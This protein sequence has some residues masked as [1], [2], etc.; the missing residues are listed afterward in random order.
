MRITAQYIL[1]FH[2]VFTFTFLFGQGNDM[3]KPVEIH[4]PN[5]GIPQQKEQSD[6]QLAA[7]FFNN[8]E[9]EK[10]LVLY[11]KLYKENNSN[12]YYT[13]YLYCLLRLEEYK[14]AEKLV[15]NQIRDYPEKPKYLVDLGYVYNES[16]EYN[17]ARK[18]FEQALKQIPDNRGGVTELANA[19]HYRNFS[20]YAVEVYQKAGR[21]GPYP[22]LLELGNLY[23]L[24][25]NTAGMITTYLDYID[26][27]PNNIASVQPRL[28]NVLKD[29]PEDKISDFL[30]Y[31][32]LTRVQK[33]PN[34]TYFS[35]MLLWLLIQQKDFEMALTQAK[36]LDRRQNLEG[37]GLYDLANICLSNKAYDQAV[38]AYNAILK[39]GKNNFLYI[40]ARIGLLYAHYMKVTST[41]NPKKEDLENLETE[42]FSVLEEY[43]KNA[44]TIQIMKHLG[45]LSAFYLDDIPQAIELLNEAIAI[46]NAPLKDIAACKI[47]LADILIL[48]GDVWDAKLLYAQVEKLFKQ[49]PIGYEAKFKNAKLSFYIGEYD[50]AKAQLDVLK[51][52]TSKLIA[53]DA[54]RL[55]V[56]IS[57][58]IDSDSSTVALAMYA[59]ADLLF[60]RH[61]NDEAIA[62]LDSIF[63]LA[64]SHPIFDEVI[65]KKAEIYVSEHHFEE[66]IVYLQ[67]VVDEYPDDITADNALFTLAG[68]Y[69][70]E[71]KE[72]DKAMECYQQLLNDYPAS[73]FTV[74]ARKKFR[75]LRGDFEKETLTDEEKFLFNL[76]NN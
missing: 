44:S 61:H 20:D 25:G 58:N 38:E 74:E 76:E 24:T 62:T 34:K 17:K 43:G 35:E 63:L 5:P 8:H 52:A 39:K 21:T 13:Y 37:E 65:L 10:A 11:E 26:Y 27:D 33:N 75:L 67:Q 55:A 6:S 22:Y 9:Y 53:N 2:L 66:A 72:D 7:K 40:D 41:G 14:Q 1:L 30:R 3:L 51:A 73:I 18:Q 60:Y 47:E 71:F 4:P 23:M 12:V 54:L 49:D 69:E 59:K 32:L 68:I 15:K 19:F 16:G 29:D 48:N 56:L 50:W 64:K 46:Y 31:E 57:D 45:H 28:Q 36:S 70:N 42:Y